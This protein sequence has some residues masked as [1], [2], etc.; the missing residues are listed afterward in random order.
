MPK[1]ENKIFV[2]RYKDSNEYVK[3]VDGRPVYLS[4]YGSPTLD[5]NNAKLFESSIEAYR[6]AS[7]WKVDKETIVKEIE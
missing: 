5:V 6:Q 2:I 4:E 1:T 7:F 3:N